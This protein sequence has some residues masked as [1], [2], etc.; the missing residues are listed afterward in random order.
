[1]LLKRTL[2]VSLSVSIR[3]DS[4]RET[5]RLYFHAGHHCRNIEAEDQRLECYR[6]WSKPRLQRLTSD[7]QTLAYRGKILKDDNLLIST[8][9]L[10]ANTG[11]HEVHMLAKMPGGVASFSRIW[12]KAKLWAETCSRGAARLWKSADL[13]RTLT[14][15]TKAGGTITT[16]VSRNK[17]FGGYYYVHQRI[18]RVR[19]GVWMSFRV[20]SLP[21]QDHLPHS[22][23]KW[24]A[25]FTSD[26]RWD[27]HVPHV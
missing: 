2:L 3:S 23:I 10:T 21:R 27:H 8:Y 16:V 6:A 12:G 22:L 25:R 17:K 18:L 14:C 9:G 20:L 1:M 19:V 24:F 5:Q 26:D 13:R 7:N 4:N 15:C 11:T